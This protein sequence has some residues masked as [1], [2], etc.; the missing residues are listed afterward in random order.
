MKGSEY[1]EETTLHGFQ[2]LRK[3]GIFNKLLWLIIIM[4]CFSVAIYFG[5]SNTLE[6]LNVRIFL[7]TIIVFSINDIL[8]RSNDVHLGYNSAFRRC[9]ISFSYNL[10][11]KPGKQIIASSVTSHLTSIL[12]S[13][14][15]AEFTGESLSAV[16]PI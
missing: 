13:K 2:Y 3:P 6:Y 5:I 16:T 15:E 1:C 7:V 14:D 9:D 8:A 12:L 10:Q 4:G 11:C